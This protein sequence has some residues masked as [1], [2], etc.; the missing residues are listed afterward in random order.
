MGFAVDLHTHTRQGSNCSYMEP[1]DLVRRAEEMGLDAVCITEHNASWE[2]DALRSLNDGTSLRLF[3][4][5]EVSTECG[6]VLV[7]GLEGE[8]PRGVRIEEL[9]RIVDGSGGVMIA[10]HPFR[11]YSVAGVTTDAEEAC[12][13][14]VLRWVDAAEVFNGLS[15]RREVELAQEVLLRLGLRGVGGSDSHAPHTLGSCFTVFERPLATVQDLVKEV[16]ASRFQAVHRGFE[17]T[18]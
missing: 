2:E 9:R 3:G 5:V 10:A 11:R 6:D 14:P 7:F 16:K 4:G 8:T 12:R 13:S 15:T 17:L 18:F 1:C